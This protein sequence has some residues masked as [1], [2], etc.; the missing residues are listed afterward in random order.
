MGIDM[1]ARE[2]DTDDL[3][4]WKRA[5]EGREQR[6]E[7]HTLRSSSKRMLQSWV[8]FW[9]KNPRLPRGSDLCPRTTG[10]QGSLF[11]SANDPMGLEQ[12]ALGCPSGTPVPIWGK[13]ARN[14]A[15]KNQPK[16]DA[17]RSQ[18]QWPKDAHYMEHC[19]G[20]HPQPHQSGKG[21]ARPRKEHWN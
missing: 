8:A 21:N 18:G 11:I 15:R 14:K 7:G 1:G 3:G 2:A 12:C 16:E 9:W 20:L 19:N 5:V 6:S 17:G 4:K 13:E 10:T